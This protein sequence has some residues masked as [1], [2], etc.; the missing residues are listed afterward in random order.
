MPLIDLSA[1]QTNA[2][3]P[4]SEPI[5]AVSAVRITRTASFGE[6]LAGMDYVSTVALAALPQGAQ[7]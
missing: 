5:A 1:V 4:Q 7:P 2:P 3:A 6:L